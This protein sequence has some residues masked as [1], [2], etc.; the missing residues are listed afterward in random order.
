MA[1][2]RN[3]PKPQLVI[4]GLFGNA[5]IDYNHVEGRGKVEPWDPSMGG[6]TKP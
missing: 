2:S 4:I 1:E 3:S 5:K 6:R